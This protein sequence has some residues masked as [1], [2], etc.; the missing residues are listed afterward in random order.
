MPIRR[1]TG[2]A[3]ADESPSASPKAQRSG[4]D[5]FSPEFASPLG[6]D[7]DAATPSPPGGFDASDLMSAFGGAAAAPPPAAAAAPPPGFG[8]GDDLLAL[9]G[10][11]GGAPAP[12][13]PV[14]KPAGGSGA[15][16]DDFDFLG[17]GGGGGG[18]P[19]AMPARPPSA[20]GGMMADMLASL[21]SLAVPSPT[22]LRPPSA[23]SGGAAAKEWLERL[24]DYSFLFAE[25]ILG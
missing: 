23:S 12:S 3:P 24:P 11:S 21:D 8:G 16:I 18:A 10:G 2:A 22:P 15:P 17:G 1:P 13:A 9:F 25:N 14:A 7:R 4:R 5:P 19:P 6:G 20:G